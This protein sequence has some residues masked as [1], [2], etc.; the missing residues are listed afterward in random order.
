MQLFQNS[1]FH[2]SEFV[3]AHTISLEMKHIRRSL[4][5]L[6]LKSLI[7]TLVT[8]TRPVDQRPGLRQAPLRW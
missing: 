5:R 1:Y 6:Q 4:L 8:G 7:P 2:E 3:L